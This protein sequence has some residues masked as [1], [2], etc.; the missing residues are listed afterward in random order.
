VSPVKN[1]HNS[2]LSLSSKRTKNLNIMEKQNFTISGVNSLNP[3]VI[4]HTTVDKSKSGQDQY[5]SEAADATDL[6]ILTDK[7]KNL[8]KI[9]KSG[10]A[11]TRNNNNKK[12]WIKNTD[13]AFYTHYNEAA[14]YQKFKN[15]KAVFVSTIDFR[16]HKN[17]PSKTN[18]EAFDLV[19]ST[20]LSS[21]PK[22]Q[23]F[24]DSMAFKEF[25]STY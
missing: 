17:S 10:F 24:R 6:R 7:Y 4:Q 11:T 19:G 22:T 14:K 25:N 20:D 8:K 21:Q 9:Q 16:N 12:N 18:T 13:H 15:L 3:S 5:S 23:K 1:N 2:D